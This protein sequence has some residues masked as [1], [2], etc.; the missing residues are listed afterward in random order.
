M[1][2]DRPRHPDA[3]SG[4]NMVR[5]S[6]VPAA[7]R[8]VAGAA[9]AG[10]ALGT[11]V[12]VDGAW[13]AAPS[14]I[15]SV[16]QAV[17]RL[18]PGAVARGGVETFG[19]A[20]KPLLIAGVVVIALIIGARV[21]TASARFP[22]AVGVAMAAFGLVGVLAATQV[23]DAGVGASVI[24]AALAAA[25]GAA[26]FSLLA[27]VGA[28]SDVHHPIGS[29]VDRRRFLGAS[30]GAVGGA[31]LLSGAGRTLRGRSAAEADRAAVSLPDPGGPSAVPAAAT[32]DADIP[33]LVT[34]NSDFYRID[35]ALI[36]PSVRLD[37]WRLRVTGMVETPLELTHDELL[38]LPL[39]ERYIT[40]ACV[41]NEVGGSL[42]GNALWLGHPLAQL[43]ER[44]GVDP[45]ADQVV[46]R[47]VD[48]FTVGF[49][50]SVATDGRDALVAVGMNGEVLP[51]RHGFPAR[52]VVPGLYGYVSATKWLTE[53][54]LTT[55][56]SFDPYW[57]ERG[58][59]RL[60]PIKTQSRIDVPRG[61]AT[62]PAGPVTVAGVA[63]A[64]HR[65]IDAVEVRVDGGEWREAELAE[66]L[67][68]DTWR[69][70]RLRWP[71]EPG[72]HVLEVRATDGE[73]RPQPEE[74]QPVFPD[75]AT[76][77]HRITVDVV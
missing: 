34:P 53:I 55:F 71:A 59:S 1:P 16:A 57:V 39:V 2:D 8:A 69:Q 31:L 29:A 28:T 9:A 43:L 51:T 42:I 6:H 66:A 27:A 11:S 56:S 40:L 67:S 5:M 26:T 10:V 49:P 19:S 18:S 72:T 70:W 37:G 62:V 35:E 38:E 25:A 76:G 64:Q 58:W 12:F 45:A 50:T 15:A 47:S 22:R 32:V 74:R 46:G 33:P 36:V 52:L 54:E 23:A 75:G 7:R 3:R 77:Y 41:S 60:G 30:A 65:G 48:G 73:N 17:I 14:L 44:A 68:I 24:T 13:P 61:G 20:D 21:G 63:W 4:P